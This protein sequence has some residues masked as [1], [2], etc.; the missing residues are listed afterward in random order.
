MNRIENASDEIGK[1]LSVIDEISFQTNLLAL[2]AG[3]EAARAG[4]SGKGFAVVAQEVRE[5]AQRSAASASDIKKLIDRTQSEIK[6]GVGLVQ[7]TGDSLI[8]LQ[9]SVIKI[10]GDISEISTTIEEQ[11]ESISNVNG[12]I[13]SIDQIAQKNAGMVRDTSSE[14][15]KLNNYIDNLTLMLERFNKGSQISHHQVYEKPEYLQ[16]A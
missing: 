9:Q 12:T 8:E 6:G 11:S 5:L 13:R 3:V 14:I 4:E 7:Q 15:T 10:D 1:I 2:N 16:S